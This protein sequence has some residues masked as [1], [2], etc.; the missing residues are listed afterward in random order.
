VDSSVAPR[1]SVD[2]V[3]CRPRREAC[4]AVL[5]DAH[6]FKKTKVLLQNLRWVV[7]QLFV[8]GRLLGF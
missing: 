1:T 7:D 4:T 5:D 6:S 8:C 3:V 2:R